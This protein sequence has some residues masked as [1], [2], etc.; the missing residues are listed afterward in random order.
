MVKAGTYLNRRTP[1]VYMRVMQCEKCVYAGEGGE[2]G[3]LS[4]G[5]GGGGEA[6]VAASVTLSVNKSWAQGLN[7]TLFCLIQIPPES[8]F[9]L[10]IK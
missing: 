5:V 10:L 6:Y 3:D 9:I 2:R 1:S 8:T 7:R 4:G